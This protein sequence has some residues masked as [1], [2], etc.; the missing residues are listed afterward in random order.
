MKKL[1]FVIIDERIYKYQIC[2]YV[3]LIYLTCTLMREKLH[4]IENQLNKN[5][6][7]LNIYKNILSRL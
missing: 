1:K 6:S 4:S 5:V 2:I 3:I 7:L